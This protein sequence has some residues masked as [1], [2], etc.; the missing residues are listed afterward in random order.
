MFLSKS[1]HPLVQILNRVVHL[2]RSSR[3]APIKHA[4]EKLT[5]RNSGHGQVHLIGC[6]PGAAIKPTHRALTFLNTLN[7]NE[8]YYEHFID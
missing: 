4:A 1:F 3:P 2:G 7:I 6:G 5:C 8:E